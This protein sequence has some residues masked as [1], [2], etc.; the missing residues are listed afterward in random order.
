MYSTYDHLQNCINLIFT[1]LKIIFMF[2][3][4]ERQCRGCAQSEEYADDLS[5][6]VKGC[7]NLTAG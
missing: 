4:H 6:V 2:A 7:T 5:K 1:K 3:F